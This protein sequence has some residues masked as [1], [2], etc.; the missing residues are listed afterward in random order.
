MYFTID[1]VAEELHKSKDWLQDWLLRHPVDEHGSPFYR[2]AGR[3]KLFRR[4]DVDRIFHALEAPS[5]RYV[6]SRPARTIPIG[7]SAAA[8]STSK[9]SI[10]LAALL[11]QRPRKPS[12]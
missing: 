10:Q 12:S 9:A 7:R 4:I 2:L 3:T 11:T 1:Q 5:C 6:S 8:I